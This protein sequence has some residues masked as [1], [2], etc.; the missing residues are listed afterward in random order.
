VTVLVQRLGDKLG[1]HIHALAN[2]IDDRPVV[3]RRSAVSIG[4]EQTFD[5]DHVRRDTLEPFLL[6]QSDRVAVRLRRAGR[7]AGTVIL[8]IKYG[9]FRSLTRQR[10]IDGGTQ[11]GYQIGRVALEL[12]AQIPI[13]DG[14]PD[15]SV[16]L[17]GVAVANLAL[18]AASRQLSFDEGDRVLHERLGKTLDSIQERF[19]DAAIGRAL[20]AGNPE[21]R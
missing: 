20:Y 6:R 4:H 1:R 14:G 16:R 17:C 11:D 10:A 3:P 8:K 5:R 12:L 2:G 21:K 15:E 19:G 9:S 18:A 7:V 13:G